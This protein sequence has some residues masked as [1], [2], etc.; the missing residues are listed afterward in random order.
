MPN[1]YAHLEFGRHVLEALPLPLR[2]SIAREKDAFLLGLFG[3]DP[4]FF[5]PVPPGR[6]RRLGMEMHRQALRPVAERLRQAIQENQPQARGYAAGF[7]CHFVLDS[8]CHGAVDAWSA[9]GPHTHAAIEAEMDRALMLQ[10]GLDPMR[11]T[12]IPPQ[13]PVEVLHK[14]IPAVYPK[15]ALWQYRWGYGCFCRVSRLLTLANGT[16]WR[17]IVDWAA[18]TF[19]GCAPIRGMVLT[20][21]PDAESV[22][23]SR[24]LLEAL[25]A[26]VPAATVALERFFSAAQ[27][28][29]WYDQDFHG[30][31]CVSHTPQ[32]LTPAAAQC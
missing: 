18:R 10:M 26:A 13:L 12:P 16:R 4:L 29:S 25:F 5:C 20:R 2:R 15:V 21:V 17:R 14:I 3:P 23:R 30:Q 22:E 19:P 24:I 7:L 8:A 1:Y 9:Q 27:L 28:D 6:P 32:E 31:P 11:D